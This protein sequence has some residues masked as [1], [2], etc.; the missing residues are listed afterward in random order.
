MLYSISVAAMLC[1][2]TLCCCS[3]V[4][5]CIT[6]Y[7]L[8]YADLACAA[9]P[10]SLPLDRFTFTGRVGR[11]VAYDATPTIPVVTVTFNGGRTS[12]EIEEDDLYLEYD[13]SMYEIWWVK[14]TRSEFVVEKKKGFNVTSPI[15]TFDTTND[16]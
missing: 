7:V 10:P 5:H 4:V 16:R 11:V 9:L 6:L 13:K 14:R 8:K 12:Y 3:V 2:A 15:C 1:Y